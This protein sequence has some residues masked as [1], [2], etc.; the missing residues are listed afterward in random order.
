MGRSAWTALCVVIVALIAVVDYIT[1]YELSLSILYLGPVCLATWTL[2]RSAGVAFSVLSLVAWLISDHMMGHIYAHPFYHFWEATIRIV[3]LIGFALLLDKLRVALA[4][5]DERFVTVLD[6][7]DAAV[8]V[9]DRASSELLYGN[10]HCTEVFGPNLQSAEQIESRLRVL[11]RGAETA[12]RGGEQAHAEVMDQQTGRWF[13]L[14]KRTMHWIDGRSVELF[15]ATDVTARKRAE[16]LSRQQQQRLEMT[17]RLT[18]LGEVASTLAHEINQP[19]AAV[20]SYCMGCVR[21]LRSGA[22]ER[23]EILAALEK[24]AAQAERA[25]RIVQRARALLRRRE[26]APAA[27]DINAVIASA[28][29]A[30][31]DERARGAVSL[32]VE[33][34]PQVPPVLADSVMIELVLLNLMKNGLEAMRYT[35]GPARELIIRTT[36]DAHNQL[37]VEIEDRGTGLPAPLA[38]QLFKPFFTTKPD[39]MGMGLHI[40]RSIIERHRGRIWATP[41]PSGGTV[42]KFTLPILQA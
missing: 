9:V 40:C 6:R 28:V 4:H 17:A 42:F 20:S 8:Y 2:G 12:L 7:L 26:P 31:Q 10:G 35:P 23:D 16:D 32:R 39:G 30:I 1:G 36:A 27:C 25:G 24:C 33:I 34:D 13:L 3:T 22:W 37:R 38:D 21:R 11:R 29:R 5:A 14:A 18:T 15:I 41:N 19:L